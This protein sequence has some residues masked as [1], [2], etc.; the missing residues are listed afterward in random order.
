MHLWGRG[1]QKAC[2]AAPVRLEPCAK[3]LT[4]TTHWIAFLRSEHTVAVTASLREGATTNKR[5]RSW[6]GVEGVFRTQKAP[7][8]ALDGSNATSASARMPLIARAFAR[9]L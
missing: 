5:W 2:E 4:V 7:Y 1:K 6:K 8:H 3:M 9:P